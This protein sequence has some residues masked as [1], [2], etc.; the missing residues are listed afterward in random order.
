LVAVKDLNFSGHTLNEESTLIQC[1]TENE[2]TDENRHR[3]AFIDPAGNFEIQSTKTNNDLGPVKNTIEDEQA[4]NQESRCN[5]CV[6]DNNGKNFDPN[7]TDLGVN[8]ESTKMENELDK[9]DDATGKHS[10]GSINVEDS[11]KCLSITNEHE[12]D[13]LRNFPDKEQPLNEDSMFTEYCSVREQ[14]SSTSENKLDI[15]QNVQHKEQSLNENI[16]FTG[17]CSEKE[18]AGFCKHSTDFIGFEN[19]SNGIASDEDVLDKKQ[20]WNENSNFIES[21]SRK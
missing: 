9:A 18:D 5:G 15:V 10:T 3:K 20:S 21:S 4:V 7:S 1:L 17:C 16:V 6:P 11:L 12:I 19:N 14:I 8:N 13:M 2:K